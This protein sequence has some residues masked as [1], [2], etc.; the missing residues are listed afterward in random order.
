V[1][2]CGEEEALFVNVLVFDIFDNAGAEV[3][4]ALLTL[5]LGL[6]PPPALD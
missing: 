5:A 4:G 6:A 2:L 3:E 1:L